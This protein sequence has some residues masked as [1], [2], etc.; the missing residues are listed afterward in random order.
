MVLL[1]TTTE[2]LLSPLRP[3]SREGSLTRKINTGMNTENKNKDREEEQNEKM[4][5]RSYNR[6]PKKRVNNND[7]KDRCMIPV[8]STGET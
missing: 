6:V 2:K 8:S 3:L 7:S 5:K 1:S 4:T